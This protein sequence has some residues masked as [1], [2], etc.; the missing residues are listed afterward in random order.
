M[1]AS[2]R[3]NALN[4]GPTT[5]L[6]RTQARRMVADLLGGRRDSKPRTGY[7]MEL[8]DTKW[9]ERSNEELRRHRLR[10]T[11]HSQ[12]NGIVTDPSLDPRLRNPRHTTLFVPDTNVEWLSEVNEIVRTCTFG[13]P[14]PSVQ[15]SEILAEVQAHTKRKRPH[16]S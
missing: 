15:I 9:P 13:D 11:D 3:P 7:M 1:D 8:D 14:N 4:E 6:P 16:R 12:T 10:R 5:P 2:N